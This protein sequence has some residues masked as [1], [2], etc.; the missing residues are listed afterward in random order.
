MF[1]S[2]IVIFFF[3]YIFLCNGVTLLLGTGC[4]NPDSTPSDSEMCKDYLEKDS[5]GAFTDLRAMIHQELNRNSS[6]YKTVQS[7]LTNDLMKYGIGE[8]VFF[9]RPPGF[10]NSD[11]NESSKTTIPETQ[12]GIETTTTISLVENS[13][14]SFQNNVDE[15]ENYDQKQENYNND[16]DNNDDDDNN[17]IVIESEID[18]NNLNPVYEAVKEHYSVAAPAISTKSDTLSNSNNNNNNV[19]EKLKSF[20]NELDAEIA[21][22]LSKQNNSVKESLEKNNQ[23]EQHEHFDDYHKSHQKTGKQ[24]VL[25]ASKVLSH[26]YSANK[27]MKK[28]KR[29][30]IQKH[31]SKNNRIGDSMSSITRPTF[32]IPHTDL[33]NKN[34]KDVM[35]YTMPAITK[36]E[37]KRFEKVLQHNHPVPSMDG[38]RFS[39]SQWPASRK[40]IGNI[41]LEKICAVARMQRR[42]F[43]FITSFIHVDFYIRDDQITEER[44]DKIIQQIKEKKYLLNVEYY[45]ERLT[46]SYGGYLLRFIC[47]PVRAY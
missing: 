30:K 12:S 22:Y 11:N 47:A 26:Y 27:K 44:C 7:G 46:D 36:D 14:F 34:T 4:L 29:K 21:K 28:S 41:L 23:E 8:V 38:P 39:A 33:I 42:K 15:Q 43:D 37:L 20:Y 35:I 24:I 1:F 18:N 9:R 10:N 17:K 6:F 16:D 45:P 2:N 40:Y 3:I 32:G 13:N 31:G 5:N 19:N 25:I